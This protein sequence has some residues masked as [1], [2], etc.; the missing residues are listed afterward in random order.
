MPFS[1]LEQEKFKR[2][3]TAAACSRAQVPMGYVGCVS[4][5]GQKVKGGV[6]VDGGV[7]VVTVEANPHGGVSLGWMGVFLF[8]FFFFL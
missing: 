3:C 5:T 4:V 1:S 8:L 6:R 7:G 2:F